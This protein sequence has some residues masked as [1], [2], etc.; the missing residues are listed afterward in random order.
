LGEQGLIVELTDSAR[1]FLAKQGFDPQFGARP[2]RRAL[3][4]FIESPLSVQLLKGAFRKGDVVL[5]EA[6]K[7]EGVKFVRQE[8]ASFELPVKTE[9][10]A[11]E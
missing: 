6:T 10:D 2:L 8:G 4:R 5:V 3:Q 1:A 7:A 11:G 9:Q